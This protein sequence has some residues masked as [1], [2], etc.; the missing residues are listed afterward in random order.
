MD[1]PK[2]VAIARGYL[3]LREIAGGRHDPKILEWW[4]AIGAPWFKDDETPW[5]GAFVGGALAEAGI[6]PPAKGAGASARAWLNFGVRLS[7]AAYGCIVVFERSGGG[8]VGFVVGQDPH[9]NLM[10]LGGNQGDA[11]NI[12]PFARARV[13]GYRWPSVY[14]LAERFNLPVLSNDGR[15][16]QNEA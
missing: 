6:A 4:R 5:C 2:W 10:V 14:P 1:D 9:G 11:V 13:L 16:S 12:K 15:L 3:G 8:H 7:R